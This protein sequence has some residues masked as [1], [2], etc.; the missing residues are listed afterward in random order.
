MGIEHDLRGKA[1]LNAVIQLIAM[2]GYVCSVLFLP[3]VG[4]DPHAALVL[5]LTRCGAG[6]APSISRQGLAVYCQCIGATRLAVS[7]PLT[8]PPVP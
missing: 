2:P 3:K 8:T 7:Q 5:R 6:L 1:A 4:L